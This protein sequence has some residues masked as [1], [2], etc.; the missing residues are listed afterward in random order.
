MSLPQLL[1]SA[2]HGAAGGGL[3]QG[4]A[5]APAGQLLA[6][7]GPQDVPLPAVPAGTQQ[8]SGQRVHG[9]GKNASLGRAGQRPV[10]SPTHTLCSPKKVFIVPVGNHSNIPF[11]RVN[12]SKFMVTEKA[13][14]I[15]EPGCSL[16]PPGLHARPPQSARSS[17][18]PG[19]GPACRRAQGS[20]WRQPALWSAGPTGQ[21]GN[22]RTELTEP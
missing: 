1:A 11:S 6:Q 5:R 10:C 22:L 18:P 4:G 21:V 13:A 7:H 14:Y 20:P 12:H 19:R 9:R 16:R 15:G 8:P 3:Q 17:C 2:G